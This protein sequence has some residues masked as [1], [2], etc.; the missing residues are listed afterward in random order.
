MHDPEVELLIEGSHM[1]LLLLLP[2]VARS[3]I[4]AADLKQT[5]QRLPPEPT[6]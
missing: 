5:T 6:L 2:H 1:F 3:P 4:S